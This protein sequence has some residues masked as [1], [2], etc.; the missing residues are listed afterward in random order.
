[1]N[2]PA[3]VR[4]AK[5]DHCAPSDCLKKDITTLGERSRVQ[6]ASLGSKQST[7]TR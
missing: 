4:E 2:G 3:A 6:N 1:M 7:F 5:S